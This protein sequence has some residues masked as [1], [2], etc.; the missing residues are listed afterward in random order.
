[1]KTKH[2]EYYLESKRWRTAAYVPFP[3]IFISL[4][5]YFGYFS[6][7]PSTL[8]SDAVLA[9][10]IVSFAAEFYIESK[11]IRLIGKHRGSPVSLREI[12]G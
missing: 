5:L 6:G 12:F 7:N 1:M 10:M 2:S 8:L 11:V 9:I 4:I 3:P